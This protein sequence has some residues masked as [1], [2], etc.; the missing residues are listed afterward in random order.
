MNNLAET[1]DKTKDLWIEFKT[2]G[3]VELRNRLIMD[4]VHLVKKIVGRLFPKYRNFNEY[5][6]LISWGVMGLMDAVEKFDLNKN[7]K[8]ETYATLR[9]RGEIIDHMRRQDAVPVNIRAKLKKI[10]YAYEKLQQKLGEEPSHDNVAAFLGISVDELHKTL[11]DSY[12]FNI[13]YLDEMLANSCSS[14]KEPI[15]KENIEENCEKDD[16]ISLIK[17]EIDVLP[18]KEKIVMQCYYYEEMTLKEIALILGLTES[19][20]AQI[21][22]KV[23]IKLRNRLKK[24]MN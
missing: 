1:G 12:Y 17:N 13:I 15:S 9:I 5:D 2:S 23:I 11:E 14:N 20:I 6:D 3:D 10:D 7:V 22:S 24:I 8:F 4:N 19:R 18:E 21:H 16:I